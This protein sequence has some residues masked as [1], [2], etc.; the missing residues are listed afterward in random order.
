MLTLGS[1]RPVTSHLLL[2]TERSRD[3]GDRLRLARLLA[4]D[5]RAKGQSVGHKGGERGDVVRET[6]TSVDKLAPR[7]GLLYRLIPSTVP[8]RADDNDM[9]LERWEVKVICTM[10]LFVSM[11]IF[12]LLPIRV[13]RAVS[14]QGKR[15]LLIISI[16]SCFGGGVFFGA[17]LTHMNPDNFSLDLPEKG[18]LNVIAI[19]TQYLNGGFVKDDPEPKDPDSKLRHPDNSQSRTACPGYET[20]ALPGHCCSGKH[21]EDDVLSVTSITSK[22]VVTSDDDRAQTR[23]IIF[24]VAMHGLGS[25]VRSSECDRPVCGDNLSRVY[26]VVFDR[27]GTRQIQQDKG[28]ILKEN[29]NND[30]AILKSFVV[31][32]G[33]GLMAGM[34]AISGTSGDDKIPADTSTIAMTAGTY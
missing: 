7:T 23:S 3:P 5:P 17:F 21:P 14:K 11:S 19:K 18:Q 27:N 34:A 26:H 30:H 8:T 31:L 2:Y 10:A 4:R 32:L 24:M 1:D 9:A 22:V 29:L 12:V 25:D 6:G 33:F 13:A 20:M 15:G 28:G 16:L